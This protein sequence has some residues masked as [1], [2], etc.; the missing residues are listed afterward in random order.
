M[1]SNVKFFQ[2]ISKTVYPPPLLVAFNFGAGDH[3]YNPI[4]DLHWY[5]VQVRL[6][7]LFTKKD[8]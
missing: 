2:V 4:K 7:I 8:K 3:T 6:F 5:V 1:L